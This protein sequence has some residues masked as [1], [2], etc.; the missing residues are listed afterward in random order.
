MGQTRRGDQTVGLPTRAFLFTLDQ[1]AYMLDLELVSLRKS[2]LHYDGRT[3]GD[4]S[5]DKMMARNIAPPGEKPEWRV[6][7][8][9]LQRWLRRKGFR[10][11]DS[12]WAVA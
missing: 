8:K 5:P 11:Y 10:L 3:V 4:R 7:E 9:E 12:N 2:Y 6:A 1:I